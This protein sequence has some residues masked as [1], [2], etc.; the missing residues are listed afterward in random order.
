MP[1]KYLLGLYLLWVVVFTDLFGQ[2]RL[3]CLFIH[4]CQVAV[5][6]A[7]WQYPWRLPVHNDPDRRYS[8]ILKPVGSASVWQLH[9]VNCRKATDLQRRNFS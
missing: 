1:R 8:V 9:L 5:H 4:Y 2:C 6:P 3:G 7:A